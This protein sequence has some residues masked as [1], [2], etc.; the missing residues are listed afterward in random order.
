MSKVE[1]IAKVS[2][3]GSFH[4]LWGLIVS[5]LISSIGA[6]FIARL[7]GSD[8]YGLYTI[9]IT[10]PLLIQVLRDWG[11]NSAM[12]RFV[13][14]YRAEGRVDEVRS[15][16]LTGVLFEV[17]MGLVLS[18]FS[19]VSADF[20]ATVVFNRPVIA[21]FIQLVS[22][23]ILANSLVV[24]STVAFTGYDRLELN[25]VMLIFQSV[26]RTAI[27][28]ALVALGFGVAGASIGYTVSA[29]V[30]GLVGVALIGVIYRRLPKPFSQKLEIKAYFTAIFSYCLPLSLATIIT[31]LLPQ[32]YAFLLPI[33]YA[34]DNVQIGNYGVAINFVVLIAFFITPISTMMF[35]AFS[36]LDPRR[37]Q[38]S[39]RNIFSFSVKYG[40]L[41]VVP[42]TALVMCL[43]EPAVATLFGNTYN[44][45]G[46]FL[47]L[48][49]IQYLYIAFG[50][51]ILPSL[52]NG[53]GQTSFTLRM[54]LLTGLIGFPLGYGLI[55][56]FGVLGLILAMLVSNLPSLFM[57]LNFVKKTYGATVDWRASVCI[58]LS[59][60]VAAVVT[61][62]MVSWLPFAAW[63]ELLLGVLVFVVVLV[64]AL[65][66][67]RSVT[68]EDIANLKL[69]VE[70]L[71]V[72]GRLISRLLAFLE[73]VM[74]FMNL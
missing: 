1:D 52:L 28:I 69:I 9:V 73:R 65:L 21:P 7:L 32:F 46:L 45:A 16:F 51:L 63:I 27:M 12:V 2:A 59:S 40:S 55:M 38:E 50:H 15:V 64:P 68:K 3:K 56:L 4:V 62:F 24:A 29:F 14:Q 5:T 41:L 33:H 19:F 60:G 20:L 23:S 22:F 66:F 43:S 26:F 34:A 67:S 47:A 13:A 37:D 36:K 53:Q 39:L 49:A 30:A 18:I 54:A 71:G 58:L 31:V 42:V 11:V 25:S 10:A 57:G 61:Y 17:V 35:P 48:F 6:I 72:L 74:T 70:G 8:L 44:T